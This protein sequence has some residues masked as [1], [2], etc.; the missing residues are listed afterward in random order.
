M[1]KVEV[2]IEQ[3]MIYAGFAPPTYGESAETFLP[4][5]KS[6]LDATT[7]AYRLLYGG[8]VILPPSVNGIVSPGNIIISAPQNDDDEEDY[9]TPPQS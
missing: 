1:R 2:L 9:G 3:A 7:E 6:F 5:L 8:R 4:R